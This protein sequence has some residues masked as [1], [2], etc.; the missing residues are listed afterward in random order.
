VA[1]S[2][3]QPLLDLAAK[4]CFW[5]LG[6]L[7]L[8]HIARERSVE[9]DNRQDSLLTILRKLI[10]KILPK[11]STD[12]MLSI[13]KLRIKRWDPLDDVLDVEEVKA[14]M[15]PQDHKGLVEARVEEEKQ[16]NSTE[17]YRKEYIAFRTSKSS[18]SK[19]GASSSSGSRKK[20]DR[21][22]KLRTPTKLTVDTDENF[23]QEH[24]QL[25]CAPACRVYRDDWNCRWLCSWGDGELRSRSWNTHGYIESGLQIARMTWQKA[26][27]DTGEVCLI[28][29][30]ML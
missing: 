21:A 25:L 18:S 20:V 12:E 10:Q 27:D 19:G 6:R 23:T 24:L 26:K 22:A 30:L 8:A 7:A 14:C 15:D 2:A 13:L 5:N 28:E 9:F 11:T 16:K 3:E 29:G 17:E 4:S 1:T